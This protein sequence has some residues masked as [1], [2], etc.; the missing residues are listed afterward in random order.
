MF[1]KGSIYT[2][3]WHPIFTFN[4]NNYDITFAE[5]TTNEIPLSKS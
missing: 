5:N 2:N 1:P 4:V 3:K